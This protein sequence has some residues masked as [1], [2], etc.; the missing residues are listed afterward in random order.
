MIA[1]IQRELKA[2]FTSSIGYVFMVVFF[3]LAGMNFGNNIYIK[4]ADITTL[5]SSLQ[6]ILLFLSPIIT[7][8]LLSEERKSK[9]DQLLLTSPNSVAR[10]VLGK[11]FGSM[12]FFLITLSV[13]LLYVVVLFIFG[14]PNIQMIFLSYFAFI[15]LVGL[16]FSIGLFVSS[17][18]D[19]QIVA[20]IGTFGI[21]LVLFIS[22]FLAQIPNLP[23]IV[24]QII[25]FLSAVKKY[26][27]FFDNLLSLEPVIYFLSLTTAFL[28]LTIRV[29]DKRRWN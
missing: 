10:I 29:I 9:T 25:E 15:L 1:I 23:K 28:F 27:M 18:T 24:L 14:T 2:Y 3:I 12:I 22:N 21:L 20:A 5:F 11:F 13:T 26:N 6:T 8:R 17:L 16:N 7:M 4:S 19:N